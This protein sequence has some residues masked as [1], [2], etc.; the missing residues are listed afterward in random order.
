MELLALLEEKR[1]RLAAS[2]LV[3]YCGYVEIPGAP[4][5]DADDCEE[6]YPD[7]VTPAAHHVLLLETLERVLSGEVKRLMIFMPPGSAKSTYASVVWPTFFMGVRPGKNI[8]HATY[9]SPLGAKFGRRCRAIT[10]SRQFKELF[11][12]ELVADNRAANDWSLTNGSTYMCGGILS[13]ITGNR[14]D[15]IVI[16]D[17]IKGRQDAD[18]PVIREKTWEEYKGSLLTRLKPSAWQ[19]IIQT[20]W[21]PDDLS[22]RI[23]PMDYA[24]Q[25]G[26]V[27][28][29]DGEAW[30][31][32]C[33]PAQ[34]ER[35]DDPL[36]RALGEY[37]WT[38][39]FTPEFWDGVK[40]VQGTRNWL[41]LY[42]QKPAPD[43][44]SVFE[45]G[46]LGRYPRRLEHYD[47]VVQSWDTA[48]KAK[49]HN[50]PSVCTTWGV[51]KTGYHLL[52]VLVKRMEF[53][54]LK[55]AVVS[56]ALKWD[57]SAV[58]IEDKSSG[59]ALIQQLRAD[60]SRLPVIPVLPEADKET[61]ARTEA[62]QVEAGLVFLPETAPWL[63]DYEQELTRHCHV[64]AGWWL[65]RTWARL[66]G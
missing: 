64:N 66:A 46:W 33:L 7:T 45:L 40:R 6:F 60:G 11:G 5:N 61:R 32:L 57:P 56:N 50:D 34:C 65:P 1:R 27:T 31:V 16:D 48:A 19:I 63:L 28:S 54:E 15:G 9:A 2:R 30:Y 39:W 49:E 13:G 44:G 10:R 3:P 37:L 47:Q 4:L 36:S 53:P 29:R 41:A 43:G 42:Q 62:P 14:A 35:A 51:T 20:R 26:W 58:L 24:G 12:C 21:H 8:I 23:L 22:G 59:E 17:P 55:R 25:S 18:S 52:D 38:E